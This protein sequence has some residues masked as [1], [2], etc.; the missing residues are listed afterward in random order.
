MDRDPFAPGILAEFRE[1]PRRVA[2]VKPSRL[3]D[4][5]CAT[6]A[7]RALGEA[8]PDAEI[9]LITLPILRDLAERLSMVDHYVAF[10]GYPGLAEQFFDARRTLRFFARMQVE[11][12]DLAVQMQGSGV[13]SNPFTLMLGASVTAGFVRHDGW[14]GKLDAALPIPREGH[15]VDRML[16]LTSFLGAP[17][18]GRAPAFEL[19]EEDRA[20]A[21][22]LL[23]GA[24]K[25]F[26][27]L[28]PGAREPH[29]AW[30]PE[31]FAASAAEL[32][33]RHGGTIILMGAPEE[34]ALVAEVADGLTGDYLNLTGRTPLSVLGAVT[35]R[36]TLLLANNSGPAHIAYAVGTPTVIV[37][38]N[39]LPERYG[40]PVDGPF[41]LVHGEE[42]PLPAPRDSGAARGLDRIEVEEV[43]AAAEELLTSPAA[44]RAAA[45]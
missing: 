9:T 3:G 43:V 30:M 12:Y 19:W 17:P 7:L 6:P 8:L 25:P 37:Y 22:V 15:E 44:A 18:R 4:F 23:A 14:A 20:A 27:G 38:G 35:S 5:I 45:G 39:V 13:Y 10:P 31:R 28:H 21:R 11:S 32:Q 42:G 33:R 36:L 16:R 41:R 40:P 2:V 26:I 1:P 34:A 24:R 29:R